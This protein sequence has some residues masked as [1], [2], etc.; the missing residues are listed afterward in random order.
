MTSTLRFIGLAVSG[1]NQKLAERFGASPLDVGYACQIALTYDEGTVTIRLEPIGHPEQAV[2]LT[3]APS[4]TLGMTWLEL[5]DWVGQQTS[6]ARGPGFPRDLVTAGM[7]REA[8]RAG[9]APR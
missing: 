8:E 3:P 6:D 2:E 5:N 4:D 7:K 1:D 9:I